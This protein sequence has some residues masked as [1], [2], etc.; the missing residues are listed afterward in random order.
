[1]KTNLLSLLAALLLTAACVPPQMA[2]TD[3]LGAS[4]KAQGD[5]LDASKEEETIT[6]RPGSFCIPRRALNLNSG[7]TMHMQDRCI[8]NITTIGHSIGAAWFCGL[9]IIHGTT[10]YDLSK[11]E[12]YEDTI[13]GFLIGYLGYIEGTDIEIR[14]ESLGYGPRI[15]V[16]FLKEHYT[17]ER[18][19]EIAGR[20]EKTDALYEISVN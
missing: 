18:D 3:D 8:S 15:Q 9:P 13:R 1:M 7:I 6:L 12:E 16:V 2:S 4:R 5:N 11:R 17:G 10:N 19:I 14:Y 20:C